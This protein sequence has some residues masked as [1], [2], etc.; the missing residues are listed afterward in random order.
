MELT[1]LQYGDGGPRNPLRCKRSSLVKA[2]EMKRSDRGLR[3]PL[4]GRLACTP[5]E[6]KA[7]KEPEF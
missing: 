6:R 5:E 7:D 1:I 3:L 2:A 4:S